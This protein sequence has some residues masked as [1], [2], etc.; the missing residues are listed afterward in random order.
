LD[1]TVHVPSRG[2]DDTHVD[3]SRARLAR[4]ANLATRERPE[5]ERLRFGH[6]IGDLVE[7]EGASVSIGEGTALT[8]LAEEHEARVLSS[9]RR[10]VDYDEGA[11]APRPG[12]VER[13]GH[14]LLARPRL[15]FDQ[16]GLVRRRRA[17]EHRV[18]AAHHRAHAEHP[19][20]PVDLG[21]WRIF[22]RSYGHLYDPQP[23][24]TDDDLLPTS[25]ERAEHA[26]ACHRRA[27][28]RAE[29]LDGHDPRGVDAER[30]VAAR[31]LAVLEAELAE[32]ARAEEDARRERI[33]EEEPLALVGPLRDDEGIRLPRG[34]GRG[35]ARASFSG[36]VVGAH[37]VLQ[38]SRWRPRR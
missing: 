21:R 31:D 34:R 38:K 12:L 3:L 32:R 35:Q 2:R 23:R 36:R 6:E 9:Q 18:E 17:L 8:V 25:H 33:V 26:D 29:V 7:Q 37:G 10:A 15:T 11:R 5:N 22:C 30:E 28:R 27:V 13:L 20:E 4:G 14:E 24:L 1:V 19:A 16:H